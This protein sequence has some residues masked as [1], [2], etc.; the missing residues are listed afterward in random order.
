MFYELPQGFVTIVSSVTLDWN[1]I[2]E[3]ASTHA[4]GVSTDQTHGQ[5]CRDETRWSQGSRL[6]LDIFKKSLSSA[7]YQTKEQIS[8]T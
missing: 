1:G 8:K 3:S 5:Y 2:A 6:G 7:F 4:R